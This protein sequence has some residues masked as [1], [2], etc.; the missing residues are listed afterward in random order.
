MYKFYDMN[1]VLVMETQNPVWIKWDK[2]VKSFKVCEYAER[3]GVLIQGGE[4]DEH[5][6]YN[7][8]IEGEVIHPQLPVVRMV[9]E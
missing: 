8:S 5:Y 3:E 7:A 9:I 4:G 2:K 6:S 1:N